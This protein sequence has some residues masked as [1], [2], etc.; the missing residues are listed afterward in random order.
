M[1]SELYPK[2]NE[3]KVNFM[4]DKQKVLKDKLQHIEKIKQRWSTANTVL[5]VVGISVTC[6]LGGASILTVAPFSVP[7]AAAILSGISLGNMAVSNL[8]VEGFTSRRKRYFKRKHDHIRGYLNKM[9][10]WFIKC[11]EDGQISPS[12]FDQFQKLL[13]DFENESNLKSE[14]K[15][16]DIRKVER[17]VKKD[18]RQQRIQQ[19]YANV[20]QEHQQNLT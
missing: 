6:I 9:E 3:D 13:K 15:S 14:I 11:K 18:V 1:T 10:A 7:I 16:K 2:L 12:E 5:K 8:L 4:L 17:L 19:L 20:L